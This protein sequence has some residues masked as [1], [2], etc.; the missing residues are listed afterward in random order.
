VTHTW[1]NIQGLWRRPVTGRQRLKQNPHLLNGSP[2]DLGV[3][4]A[5]NLA[6]RLEMMGKEKELAR[7]GGVFSSLSEE[8]ERLRAA[9]EYSSMVGN[10]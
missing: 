9:L 5:F 4:D 6:L 8:L 3:D 2:F 7:A 1:G 10:L